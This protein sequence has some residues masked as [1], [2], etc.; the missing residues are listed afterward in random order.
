[1]KVFVIGMNGLG[2]MPTTPRKA[3]ILVKEK[4]AH[5]YCKEPYTIMLDYKTGSATQEIIVGSDPGQKHEGIAGISNGKVLFKMEI[6]F[7]PTTDKKKRITARKEFR[8]GRRHRNTEYRE[9]KWKPHRVRK[10]H[11]EPVEVKKN[12]KRVERHWRTEKV[13]FM[14]ERPDG[15]LPPSVRSN[16]DHNIFWIA[17]IMS[18]LPPRSILRI[19]LGK[20]VA[21]L[22]ANPDMKGVDFQRGLGYYYRN[23]TEYLLAKQDYKCPICGHRFDRNHKPR[24]HHWEYVSKGASDSWDDI[25]LVCSQCHTGLA[26][27]DGGEL[28]KLRKKMKRKKYI[29]PPFMNS[30]YKRLRTAFPN[31]EITYGYIT[32]VDREY[33]GIPKTHANDAVAIAAGTRYQ[34]IED[35]PETLILKQVRRKKRNLH[36]ANPRKGRGGKK[37]TEAKRHK[38]NVRYR[39]VN[40]TV[41]HVWDTVKFGDRIGYIISFSGKSDARVV[42]WDG[43]YI[44]LEGKDYTQVPLSQLKLI[45]KRTNNYIRKIRKADSSPPYRK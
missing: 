41:F 37:N 14:S 34:T 29:E 18:L 4:K 30:T 2:L 45:E 42:D 12:G 5:V 9:P 44:T 10:Y 19:E 24:Q 27:K 13:N 6:N 15:W 25:I 7:I 26:H 36:E 8:R 32:A 1:M 35:I 33:L 22:M 39:V 28:D 17:K 20:F 38:K 21:Q 3:R 31:A 23:I 43:N 16:C 11:E 40:D